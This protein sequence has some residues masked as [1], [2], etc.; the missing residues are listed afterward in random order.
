MINPKYTPEC[1]K[2]LEEFKFWQEEMEK[3]KNS[4]YYFWKNYIQYEGK[5]DLT[6]EEFNKL[7][8]Q[9]NTPAFRGRKGGFIYPLTE[10]ECFKPKE[11]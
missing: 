9:H 10:D 4:P 6:E 1:L 2:K 11:L 8:H 3:C 7:T 5:R